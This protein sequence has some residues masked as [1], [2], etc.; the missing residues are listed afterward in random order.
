MGDKTQ[1]ATVALAARFHSVAVVA[2]GTTLGMMLA[3]GPAVFI[4]Q[5]AATRLPLTYIRWA[6]AAAF[7]LTGL[8][9]L[10]KG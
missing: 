10:V 3:N 5:A 6:A 1:V 8:W 4:S 2:A 9:V 7:A